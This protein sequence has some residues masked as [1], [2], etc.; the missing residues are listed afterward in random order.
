MFS[1]GTKRRSRGGTRSA[2]PPKAPC[3]VIVGV[4][5]ERE[6]IPRG[7]KAPKLWPAEPEQRERIV[8]SGSPSPPHIRVTSEP[9]IVPTVRCMFPD[10]PLDGNRLLVDDG[11][12]AAQ[13]ALGIERAMEPVVLRFDAPP[14]RRRHHGTEHRGEVEPPGSFQWSIGGVF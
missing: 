3:R 2:S 10:R 13:S 6:V 9:R 4:A 7:T 8:S 1:S 5:F 11:V 14:R 12:A